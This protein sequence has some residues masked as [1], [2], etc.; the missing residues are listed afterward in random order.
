MPEILMKIFTFINL[1]LRPHNIFRWSISRVSEG[2]YG[3]TINDLG[4]RPEKSRKKNF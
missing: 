1:H 4:V 3:T 2:T